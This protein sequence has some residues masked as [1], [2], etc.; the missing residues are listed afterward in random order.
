MSQNTNLFYSLYSNSNKVQN[1]G[2]KCQSAIDENDTS[3]DITVGST[4]D[5]GSGA[6]G[7]ITDSNGKTL[8]NIDLSSIHA[9]GITQYNSETRILQPYSCCLLQGQEYGLACASYFFKIPQKLK[10][11]E[12]YEKYVACDFDI[13]Y[14]N[15][16]PCRLHVST[17]PDGD[18]NFIDL[19]NDEL[20]NNN[21]E[22]NVSL[23]EIE[24]S[25]DKKKYEYLVFTS[26]K[27]GYFYYVNNLKLTPKF[28]SENLPY[29]PFSKALSGLKAIIYDFIEQYHPV[30][31]DEIY[32]E[33]T[34][35]VDCDLYKWLI[36]NYQDATDT[37]NA[38]KKAL[39]I[40]QKIEKGLIPEEE[41]D[42][43]LEE[44]NRLIEYTPW[45]DAII[46]AYD[47]KNMQIIYNI[48]EAIK[49]LINES[50]DYYQ[51][52]YWLKE[53]IRKRIP[54][55]KYPNGAFRGIVV[56]PEWPVNNSEDY[57]YSSL[58]INHVKSYVKLYKATKEGQYIAKNYGVLSNATLMYE[59][60]NLKKEMPKYSGIQS[61]VQCQNC[62][63]DG[64]NDLD[65]DYIDPYRP[66][67]SIYDDIM[68]MGQ[69][70]YANKRNII[71]IF[72]YMQYVNENDLW[73]KVGQAYIIIGNK[74]NVQSKDKNL[75]TS[76]IIYNPNPVP[77]RI[78]YFIFS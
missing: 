59:Q 60:D 55:M 49:A 77:I 9:D 46:D 1:S 75:P 65:T 76:L 53:D 43:Y 72:R 19:V 2:Y 27:T 5:G 11:T 12:E 70:C 32:D 31:K 44:V 78:K 63:Q 66:D 16:A 15:F 38:F 28:Q 54:L 29:S 18:N 25:C 52:L 24:D 4:G 64:W 68:Y 6:F 74:D 36:N 13:I 33:T 8:A 58:W 3:F 50:K 14:N 69:N 30:K 26:E 71:G 34:Y 56:I 42:D 22:I 37:L 7:S 67:Q 61:N 62:I 23:Q 48:V 57:E 51:D 10:D 40:L 41:I 39:E 21:V 17:T 45:N 47:V 35:E 73:N 20:L